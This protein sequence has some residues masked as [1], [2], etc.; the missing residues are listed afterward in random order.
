MEKNEDAIKQQQQQMMMYQQQWQKNCMIS[1]ITQSIYNLDSINV[2]KMLAGSFMSALNSMYNQ[3][4]S[5]MLTSKI[6]EAIKS[7]DDEDT[8]LT[9]QNCLVQ[10]QNL[11]T[12]IRASTFMGGG[13]GMNP[14]MN[15]MGGMGMGMPGMMGGM[16]MNPQMNMMG[17]GMMNPMM[18]GMGMGMNTFFGNQNNQST[19]EGVD[20][21]AAAINYISNGIYSADPLIYLA[22]M[23]NAGIDFNVQND[24]SLD[25]LIK[26]CLY[27]GIVCA[28]N[29]NPNALNFL[30]NLVQQLVMTDYYKNQQNGQ[31]SQP[32]MMGGMGMMNPM[33]GGM[34]MGMPGM[35]G[36]M[37]MGMMPPMMNGMDASGMGMNPQMNMM[38]GMGMMNPMM[39]GMGMGMPG[40]MGPTMMPGMGC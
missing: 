11:T 14:Q 18:G 28:C 19:A 34:G 26:K 25:D 3:Y 31:N 29:T 22:T 40:M 5:Q 9:A 37:G 8:L 39:G 7:I 2:I 16:G 13:M 21:K 33:M 20:K 15:M 17:M 1:Q 35:M 24:A 27:S 36:G 6:L 4:S 32:N 38:G 23:L 30:Y 10:A 12:S